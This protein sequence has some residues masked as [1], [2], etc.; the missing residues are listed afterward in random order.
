MFLR[1]KT[2]F[3]SHPHVAESVLV[4]ASMV[5]GKILSLGW[6]IVTARQ[7]PSAIGEV[8]FILT[9]TNLL[10]T[11]AIQGLPMAITI[12][13]ARYHHQ[14]KLQR[15]LLTES[16]IFALLT[17]T[18]LAL[19]AHIAFII[20]PQL[21]GQTQISPLTYLWTVPLIGLSELIWAWLNG[22]K[23]YSA[24][25]FGKYVGQPLLRVLGVISL[26]AFG[27]QAQFWIPQHLNLAVVSVCVI[28][29]LMG[30]KIWQDHRTQ[31][32]NFTQTWPELRTSYWHQGGMLSSSLVLYVL[33][34]SSDIY[35][36]TA[37]H[38]PATVGIFSLLL[39][40]TALLDLLFLP[41]LNLLQ[42]RLGAFKDHPQAGLAFLIK[43]SLLS[44]ILGTVGS[45]VLLVGKPWIALLFGNTGAGIVTSQLAWLLIWKLLLNGWV[46]P[47][48]HYLD[49][50][51]LQKQTLWSMLVSFVIK[52]WLSWW[53]VPQFGLTGIIIANLCA[54]IIHAGVLVVILK[55]SRL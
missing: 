22:R 26:L 31:A 8:E 30:I 28:S 11:L 20:W 38:G 41:I 54:E 13:T 19:V 17:G 33:Y 5:V 9:T 49:F 32:K 3:R 46:L 44:V 37:F 40:V 53:L 23:E 52:L 24:Y 16:I 12:W 27:L 36:L 42:T 7:G 29:L 55:T 1:L 48:R 47:V 4:A 34:G 10:A 18:G 2:F 25:A 45:L 21:I 43:H 51:G 35:W 14:L 6:K 15:Q 39:A 50:F